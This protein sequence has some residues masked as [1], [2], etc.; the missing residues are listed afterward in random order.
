[1]VFDIGDMIFRNFL[2]MNSY[3][4]GPFTGIITT[5]IVQFLLVPSVFIFMVLYT[6]TGRIFPERNLRVILGVTAYLFLVTGGY[7]QTF[8][9]I[10]GPYFLYLIFVLGLLF[11]LR[12]HFTRGGGPYGGGYSSSSGPHERVYD[13]AKKHLPSNISRLMGLPELSPLERKKLEYQIKQIDKQL[14]RLE[15]QLDQLKKSNAQQKDITNL[16]LQIE[17]RKAQR[18]MLETELQGAR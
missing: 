18:D 16:I 13:Q 17:E 2:Q 15:P 8:A 12:D 10:A 3:P 9:L 4:G 1:M 11:L 5:D 14:E 6:A 7:Y